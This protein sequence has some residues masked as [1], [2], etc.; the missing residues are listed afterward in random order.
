MPDK[1]ATTKPPLK[2]TV[3]RAA[4]ALLFSA[5]L[6]I[7]K[8]RR[9]RRNV[10][11]WTLIRAAFIAI[12]AVLLWRAFVLHISATYL[13]P[14]IIFVLLGALVRAR[15]VKK[16]VDAVAAELNALVVVNG[17]VLIDAVHLKPLPQVSIFVNP[18][19]LIV[20]S[21]NH[22]RLEEIPL[23]SIDGIAAHQAFLDRAGKHRKPGSTTPAT[24][25]WDLEITWQSGEVSTCF[26]YEGAFAAHLA[27]IAEKTLREIWKKGL[28][29]IAP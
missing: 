6:M 2:H 20:L 7:P 14:G 5:I 15:P 1:T 3:L 4:V 8:L 26:R 29:V 27:G 21:Q 9:L 11:L 25:V 18:S 22:Q 19:R 12:G 24:E 13:I 23:A 16:S 28:P 17:G 10:R